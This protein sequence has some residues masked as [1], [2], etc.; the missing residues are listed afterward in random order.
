MSFHEGKRYHWMAGWLV[1]IG[2]AAYIVLM[3]WVI[4]TLIHRAA[5]AVGK[6]IIQ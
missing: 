5:Y 1:L 3:G 4:G 6:W 2:F